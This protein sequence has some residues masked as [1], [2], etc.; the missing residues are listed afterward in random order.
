[1]KH[2]KLAFVLVL[3]SFVE[4]GFGQTSPDFEERIGFAIPKTIYFTGE[5]IWL[6]IQVETQAGTTSS[7]VGYAELWNR[8]G[9]SVALAKVPLESGLAFNF[10]QIP[11][12][13][14]SDHYLLRVFTRVSPFQNLEE[15]LVQEFVTVFNPR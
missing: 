13:L 11:D 2:L 10:L 15:G 1:M 6:S 8:Y 7:R 4:E 5:K 9:E 14:P 12:D 3:L